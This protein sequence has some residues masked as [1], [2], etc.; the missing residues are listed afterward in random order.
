LPDRVTAINLY[1]YILIV[2][3]LKHKNGNKNIILYLDN[4]RY[5]SIA[6]RV[7]AVGSKC[8]LFL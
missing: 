5:P 6:T 4:N 2:L 3:F 1:F 7:Y 8:I